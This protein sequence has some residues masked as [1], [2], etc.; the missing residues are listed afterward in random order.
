MAHE[1]T[2][3]IIVPFADVTQQMIDDCCEDSFDT[4]RHSLQGTDRIVLKWIGDTPASVVGYTQ[5]S[6][7]EILTEMAGPDWDIEAQSSSSSSSS[8]G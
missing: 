2:I 6:H 8:E 3:Y 5:Y 1:N 4:L 7:S